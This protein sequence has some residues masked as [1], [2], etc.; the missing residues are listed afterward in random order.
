MPGREHHRASALAL[1]PNKN[2]AGHSY[3]TRESQGISLGFISLQG[4]SRSAYRKIAQVRAPHGVERARVIFA[5]ELPF[6][7][8][9]ES[10]LK[11][12]DACVKIAEGEQQWQ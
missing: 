2:I 10:V 1:L 6:T 5:A 11:N 7:K 4:V 8:I 9:L 12:D 3:Q